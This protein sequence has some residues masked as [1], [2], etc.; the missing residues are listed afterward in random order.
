MHDTAKRSDEVGP[1]GGLRIERVAYG[2]PD[3]QRLVAELQALYEERY[4]TTDDDPSEAEMFEPPTG[5]F[6]IAY[7][8]G[9][10]VASGA[11]R[12]REDT[13]RSSDG[14]SAT[15]EIKRLYVVAGHTRRGFAR[16]MLAHLERTAA[17]AGYRRL[18]LTT[19]PRQPEAIALY[20]STGY[21]D[22]APFGYYRDH[23]TAAV[24]FLGKT[25]S[26]G[27]STETA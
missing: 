7:L 26:P 15:A 27:G 9:L 21:Q 22:I 25:I 1:D 4:G 3:T 10:P 12:H 13:D 2:H 18:I 24:T 20:R 5:A 11:W 8:D 23:A 6:F 19:G 16:R 17:E 14:D